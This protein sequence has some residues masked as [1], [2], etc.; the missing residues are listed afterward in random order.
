[1]LF[2]LSKYNS[3]MLQ[4]HRLEDVLY[5]GPTNLPRNAGGSVAGK[6]CVAASTGSS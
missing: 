3:S 4:S 1:M 6:M 5:A 2:M